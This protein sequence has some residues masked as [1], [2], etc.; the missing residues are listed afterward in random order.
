MSGLLAACGPAAAIKNNSKI[1]LY[2]DLIKAGGRRAP[3]P[4]RVTAGNSM[5]APWCW[6]KVEEVWIGNSPT[7]LYR[8][9]LA[10][11]CN[12]SRCNC[13]V[14]ASALINTRTLIGA[15]L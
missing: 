2:I 1:P 15:G 3:S 13:T 12:P 6:E 11:Q 4:Q 7:N 8:Y 9:G 5:T 14:K 10:G